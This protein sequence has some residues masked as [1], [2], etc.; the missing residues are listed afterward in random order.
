MVFLDKKNFTFKK[1]NITKN[2]FLK[3]ELI[4]PTKIYKRNI[5]TYKKEF[6]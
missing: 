5:A 2:S 4:R 1:I 6:N 3:R